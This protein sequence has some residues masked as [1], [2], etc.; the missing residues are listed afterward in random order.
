MENYTESVTEFNV[1]FCFARRQLVLLIWIACR[2]TMLLMRLKRF[3]SGCR[4]WFCLCFVL[5]KNALNTH[6]F[7]WVLF[8]T[9]RRWKKKCLS[10]CLCVCVCVWEGTTLFCSASFQ[11]RWMLFPNSISAP[12]SVTL[13][14]CR[15]CVQV[16]GSLT[17]SVCVCVYN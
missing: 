2:C 11:E 13:A 15:F 5:Q 6:L 14:I 4:E 12:F 3:V 10:M 17:V 16:F 1:I 7:T 9:F 8:A